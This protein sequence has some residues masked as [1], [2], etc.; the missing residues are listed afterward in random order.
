[1]KKTTLDAWNGYHSIP[2]CPE[3]RHLTTFITP[4]GR[5]RYRTAPQGYIA[6]GD[7]YTRRYDELVAHIGNRTKC[8][9]DV[10]LWSQ[11][12]EESFNQAIDWLDLCGKCGITLNPDKFKFAAD[13]VEFAGFEISTSHVRPS[14]H[15]T[16]AIAQFPSP[17][18]ITDIRSWFGLVN[19]VSYAFSTAP[20]MLPFRELLRPG[21]QFYWDSTLEDLFNQ[22]K[23]RII[24][25]IEEGVQIFDKKRPTCLA[26]DW[27]RTG[28]GFWLFQKHCKCQSTRPLCCTS[29]WKVTLV[30]SRFTSAAESRY[31]PVEGEALA[32]TYALEKARH[33]VLGCEDLIVAVDHKP[34]IKI[35][36]DRNLE[37]LPNS[38][39]RN[40]K[41]KSLRYR[42]R[43][44]H[45]PGVKN[46]ASDAL[47]RHP[48]GEIASLD[49]LQRSLLTPLLRLDSVYETTD[50]EYS[51]C[52]LSTLSNLPS[53]S[54]NDVREA[55]ASDKEMS[56]L[57]VLI[58]DGFPKLASD[59]S[60]QL[61]EYHKLKS[62]LSTADN[63]VLYDDRIVVPPKLRQTVLA[64]LHSAHQGVSSMIARSESSV[65]WPGITKDIIR[66]RETCRQCNRMTPSQPRAPPQPLHYSAYPFQ[67]ICADFFSYK[68]HRYLVVV[69]R[70]S[71]W[72]IVERAAEGALGLIN[73]L[74][75]TF[76]TFGIPDELTSDGG[77]EFSS[78]STRKFLQDWRVNHRLSSVAHPQGNCRAELG[79]KTIKRL[80]TDNTNANGDLDNND[81]QR[82]ILQYR[83]TPD[84][85]TKVSPAQCVFGHPIRDSI[86]ILPSKYFPHSTWRQTLNDRETAL[87][88]RHF[89][90]AE[91][92]TQYTRRLPPLKIGDHVRIQNQV[93]P[94][95]RRWDKTGLVIEVRQN[96]QYVI[97][98]DGSNR[99]S[100][101]N[102]QFLR[103]FQPI[104]QSQQPSHVVLP[105]QPR[106]P[107]QAPQSP[108][109]VS[110]PQI[111]IQ[112]PQSP[113]P[114]SGSDH[115]PF[116][117]HS[118]TV[119]PSN[120]LTPE[121]SPSSTDANTQ[122][123]NG[124]SSPTT[125]TNGETCFRRSTRERRCPAW[126]NSGEYVPK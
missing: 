123:D 106:I 84:R 87:R 38:R 20:T 33:F 10:L 91:R 45:I 99:V 51:I 69:D 75:N 68:G 36:T 97:R 100:L 107:F 105:S 110:Q 118:N 95:H 48:N 34:L 3:D 21:S 115:Q 89:V 42:F 2:L 124:T 28:V 94:Q 60:P 79:V 64:A 4:W 113:T 104:H 66:E 85:E 37:D 62:R 120:H 40:L 88:F 76:V 32:V 50:N 30:G 125:P 57:L 29:G 23:Q 12:I 18:N 46:K 67:H 122:G 58:E 47:S 43:V 16:E 31:A 13:T 55:T 102:R 74:R 82:A 14:N 5:Y 86:P 126:Q 72:P 24:K 65:F 7:A 61:R 11:S 116:N 121:Q 80:I 119:S 108:T 101:R 22:S 77:P 81:F 53:I 17:R 49:N 109:P 93:G 111:P 27:S 35:F 63:V 78:H 52:N 73:C 56:D 114:N 19:Q 117:Q 15:Y 83:N 103:R 70:Y 59:V 1:M 90:M 112:A 26:T 96:N 92:L 54:W 9:D 6:S 8:I 41:E 39:L 71:N 25:D 44:L 98:T